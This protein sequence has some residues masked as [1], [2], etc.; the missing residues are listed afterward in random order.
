[1]GSDSNTEQ[2]NI[3][4]PEDVLPGFR[5]F[6]LEF[7]WKLAEMSNHLLDLMLAGLGLD[8]E[9]EEA[10]A[11]RDIHISGDYN[12]LRL[13]HYLPIPAHKTWS[14]EEDRL[15]AHTDLG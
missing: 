11:I 13:L 3:W 15:G 1:M 7:Y 14:K 4:L 9:G 2:E 12:H 5:K 10:K 6:T 8:L